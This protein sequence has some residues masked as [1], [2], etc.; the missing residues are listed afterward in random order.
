MP[1]PKGPEP[2]RALAIRLPESVIEACD[3]YAVALQA[4]TPGLAIS[5][6]EAMRAL[7]LRGLKDVGVEVAAKPVRSRQG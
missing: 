7:L 4:K 6:N 3:R 2:T 1:R 5:R